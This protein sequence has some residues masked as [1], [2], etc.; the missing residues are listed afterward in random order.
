MFPPKVHSFVST[1]VPIRFSFVTLFLSALVPFI[2]F[3]FYLVTM[4]NGLYELF[5]SNLFMSFQVHTTRI[6]FRLMCLLLFLHIRWFLFRLVPVLQP[7]WFL[8]SLV[9]TPTC[10]LFHLLLIVFTVIHTH[11][12]P[13]I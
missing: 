6:F 2:L 7:L 12:S 1:M 10:G 13:I 9:N 5:L 4:F 8:A 11:A 3:L